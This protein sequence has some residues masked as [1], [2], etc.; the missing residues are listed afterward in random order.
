MAIAFA[1]FPCAADILGLS[2]TL[3]STLRKQSLDSSENITLRHVDSKGDVV[4]TNAN[5]HYD[6][7][8]LALASWLAYELED[9]MLAVC[10]GWSDRSIG[11]HGVLLVWYG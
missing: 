9:A 2:R 6:V 4:G 10:C 8:L 3:P 1:V 11:A 7:K 5:V